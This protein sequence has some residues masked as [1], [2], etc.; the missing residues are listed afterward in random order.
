MFIHPKLEFTDDDENIVLELLSQL[1][2]FT[3]LLGGA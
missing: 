2:T 3:P 1:D